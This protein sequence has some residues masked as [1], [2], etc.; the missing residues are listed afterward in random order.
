MS[1][2]LDIGNHVDCGA[3]ASAPCT[4]VLVVAS[5]AIRSTAPV[6]R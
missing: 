6:A 2:L 4:G 1:V 5:L 3:A